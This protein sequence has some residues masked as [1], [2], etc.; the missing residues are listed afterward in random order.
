MQASNNSVMTRKLLASVAV[1]V[2]ITFLVIG[3][4]ALNTHSVAATSTNTPVAQT[5]APSATTSGM[6]KDGTYMAAGSYD[7]PGGKQTIK[8]SITI[9]SNTV[10]SS[11]VQGQAQDGV[12]QIYQSDFTNGYKKFVDGKKLGDIKISH[13]SGSSLTSQGF[14]NALKQIENQAK[15]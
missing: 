13:V 6:Y 10:S 2:V 4:K 7:S 8:V 15:A 5:T 11:T 1:L 3:A 12:A 14:N 9:A